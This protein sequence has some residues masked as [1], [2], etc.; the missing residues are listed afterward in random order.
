MLSQLPQKVTGY[1][2]AMR[3]SRPKIAHAFSKALLIVRPCGRGAENVEWLVVELP[4]GAERHAVLSLDT[5]EGGQISIAQFEVDDQTRLAVHDL[6]RSD[7]GDGA[8]PFEQVVGEADER[9]CTAPWMG[10]PV[11]EFERSPMRDDSAVRKDRDRIA[12]R[13]GF[14]QDVRAHDDR[15]PEFASQTVAHQRADRVGVNGIDRAR[16]VGE[17][18]DG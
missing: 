18:E 17:E 3:A 4:E 9:K 11:P 1:E 7:A 16:R 12:D 6:Y 5:E 13:P 15:L 8:Q 10:E 14:G 2:S